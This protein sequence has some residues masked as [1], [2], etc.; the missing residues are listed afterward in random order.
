MPSR[1]ALKYKLG[2]VVV[3]GS[4]KKTKGL[5]T[6]AVQKLTGNIYLVRWYRNMAPTKDGKPTWEAEADLQRP[7]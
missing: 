5:V 2:D 7:L 4:R 1:V 6:D 3:L